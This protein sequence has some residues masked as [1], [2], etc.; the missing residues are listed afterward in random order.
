MNSIIGMMKKATRGE[1][2]NTETGP[3]EPPIMPIEDAS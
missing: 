2:T 3:S 1:D